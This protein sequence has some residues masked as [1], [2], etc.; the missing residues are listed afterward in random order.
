MVRF[1]SPRTRDNVYQL[2]G[3][4]EVYETDDILS[5]LTVYQNLD[6]LWI[7]ISESNVHVHEE[8]RI[9]HISES[10]RS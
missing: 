1:D 2:F 3:Q 9:L 5:D 7:P 4:A 10:K 8:D 6:T